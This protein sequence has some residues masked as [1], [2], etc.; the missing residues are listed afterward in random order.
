MVVGAAGCAVDRPTL[1]PRELEVRDR[2]FREY[3]TT[4]VAEAGRRIALRMQDERAHVDATRSAGYDA[5]EPVYDILIL[6][7]GGDYGAFGAGFLSGW[8]RVTDP[9]M[10]R[11]EFDNVS[12]VSTGALIA[13]F[14]F[15]GSHISYTQILD[16]YTHPKDDWLSLKDWLY[17]LPWRASFASVDGLKRDLQS[18]VTP[19]VI[20]QVA[21]ESRKN[22]VLAINTTN[23]DV[24][25][26]HPFLLSME[27][28]NAERTQDFER[29]YQILLASAAIPAVFPPQ[30]IDGNLY[31]DGGATANILF[32]SNWC[33]PDGPITAFRAA[34]PGAPL[35][36]IRF[37]VIINNQ[38]DSGP[39]VVRPTWV[40]I[41]GASL[42]TAI[43]ASTITSLRFLYEQTRLMRAA[44][45][46]D[47]EFR[48]VAIP[49]EWHAPK[50][51]LFEEETMRSLAALG[52]KLGSNPAAW[53]ST[54][55]GF[56][57][58]I[59]PEPEQLPSAEAAETGGERGP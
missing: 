55:T 1:T 23:L 53:R 38:L 4:E 40:S 31:V 22:R 58:D 44:D 7:G 45:G 5:A 19:E 42:S 43:R 46:L 28:E 20:R 34:H 52:E 41:T 8:G 56:E 59:M 35:P 48:F 15:L 14:A 37:W 6:S 47:V 39:Q 30:I 29:I 57:E 13:P 25:H 18:A 2:A 54:F 9:E 3:V 24:G 51:G 32:R 36:K 27:A 12:G 49:D 17:F 50:P 16:L 26:M 11:P 10:R 33:E 21:A